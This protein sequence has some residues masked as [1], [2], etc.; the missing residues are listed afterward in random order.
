MTLII[1]ATELGCVTEKSD[2][3]SQK[4]AKHNGQ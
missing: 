2:H 1:L 4:D 3:S